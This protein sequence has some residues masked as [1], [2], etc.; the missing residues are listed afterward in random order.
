MSYERSERWYKPP[1]RRV[2]ER[3]KIALA[4]IALVAVFALGAHL[5][6]VWMTR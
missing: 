1:R 2:S 3:T 6:F 4:L 5:D